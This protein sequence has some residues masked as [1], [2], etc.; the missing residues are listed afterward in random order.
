VDSPAETP[1]AFTPPE[2]QPNIAFQRT[3]RSD[4]TPQRRRRLRRRHVAIAAG[5]TLVL[6]AVTGWVGF[7]GWRA[8]GNLRTAAALVATLRQQALVGDIRG[9]RGTLQ[10]LQ[11][12]A[13][14]A[15]E[16]TSGI[17][18][19]SA[20]LLPWVGD[21]LAAARTL[22]ATLV[23][24]TDNG[25]PPLLDAAEALTGGGL[26]PA[27][28]TID[29]G[30]LSRAAESLAAGTEVVSRSTD[31]IASVPAG[32]LTPDVRAAVS[33]LDGGLS[34]LSGML[35]P[36]ERVTRLLPAVLG[37]DAP[38]RYL[39][40]FQNNA[41]VRAT[42]GMPGA[43][44]VVEAH[45]GTVGIVGQGSAAG[46]LQVFDQPVLPLDPDAEDLYTERL[47]TY[48]A[49][50]NL[51][52]DFP[53]VAQLAR[54]MYRVRTGTLVDGVIATDPVALSYLLAAIGPVQM[55]SG[56]PLT[57]DSAVRLLLSQV[58]AGATT[59]AQ[60]DAYFATAAR[61]TFEALTK[62]PG[63]PRGLAAP[64]M[65]AVTER[66]LLFWSADA[67]EQQALAG[68]QLEGKLPTDD[69]ASPGVGLFL[70]DGS[71]AKLGYYLTQ[72]AE[73]TTGDCTDD[74]RR[75]IRVKVTLG[76]SAPP[77]GLSKSVL[78]LGLSG[79][80]YTVRTNLMVFS[81]TGG[82]IAD[83]SVDGASAPLGSGFER[84]R[85]VAVVTIDLPPKTQKTLTVTLLTGPLPTVD[86]PVT[87]VVWTTPGVSPWRTTITPG[88]PC[89]K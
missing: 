50:I 12:E 69:G 54:E 42:G 16:R 1:F 25:I 31:R 53:T 40:L 36:V 76:S 70:N 30:V 60:Q 17:G 21:D 84:G 41:E 87:P 58:Y 7:D 68:T 14:A 71:G 3:R 4:P 32:G 72:S 6:L 61:A 56:P 13:R 81:P 48:P 83:A 62:R 73:V 66:R 8:A 22:A 27:A 28:G 89:D 79:D 63:D 74:R 29:V 80:P 59:S 37:A 65:R 75:E 19:R 82:S 15:N 78:G 64:L 55:P 77:S 23:D 51:T 67:D 85:Q 49:D 43:F 46:V 34:K 45:K 44:V 10:T 5:L 26:T 86:T 57:A 47:G 52:P 35:S 33:Q 88:K 20:A 38:R 11:R 18:W 2:S 9:A 24:L 39:M